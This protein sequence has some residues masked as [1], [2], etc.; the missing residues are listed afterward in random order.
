VLAKSKELSKAEKLLADLIVVGEERPLEEIRTI[1]V[2]KLSDLASRY[3]TK[4]SPR[5]LG[6][7]TD[8]LAINEK[9]D[10]SSFVFGE[11]VVLRP[12]MGYSQLLEESDKKRFK[13][14]LNPLDILG[15]KGLIESSGYWFEKKI[16]RKNYPR[17]ASSIVSDLVRRLS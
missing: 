2:A 1:L 10:L 14:R 16:I 9:G 15:P 4:F 13:M 3:Q 7:L 11:R 6:R 17:W 8:Q 5:E 12:G